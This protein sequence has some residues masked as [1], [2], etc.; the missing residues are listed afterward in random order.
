MIRTDRAL[1]LDRDGTLIFDKDYLSDPEEVE[2]IPG[3]REALVEALALGYGLFL[4]TNQSGVGRGWYSLADVERCN[5]RM[6]ELLGLP[7]PG[8]LEICIAPEPSDEG[9]VYR[10]PSPR[11]IDETI[12]RYGL[13]RERC[14]M[15]GDRDSDLQAGLN[16]EVAPVLVGTG[17][18]L[19]GKIGELIREHRIDVFDDL[20]AFVGSLTSA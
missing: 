12:A 17:F 6:F 15:V 2:L 13:C 14:F 1:F 7:D 16:A 9:A 5:D 18:E 20:R 19:T 11:F 3:V 4:H 8:F 10:K